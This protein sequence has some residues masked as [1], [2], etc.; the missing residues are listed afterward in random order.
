MKFNLIA[1][2]T[3]LLLNSC[4]TISI[5]PIKSSGTD[6]KVQR[7]IQSLIAEGETLAVTI[8]GGTRG[9]ESMFSISIIN[10]SDEAVYFDENT[11][12]S[13]QIGNYDKNQWERGN[14]YT[15][16]DY[17]RKAEKEATTSEILMAVAVGLSAANAGRSTSTYSGSV[18][19]STNSG[20]SY[21]G[22][23]SGQI[24]TYD[25]AKAQ[26]EIAQAQ[27][28]MYRVM[29][30]NKN[31]LENLSKTLLY[32]SEIPAKSIYS[33]FIFSPL[34]KAPDMKLLVEINNETFEFIFRRSDYQ[35]I[36]NPFIAYQ[37]TKGYIGYIYT[38]DA[39]FG[40]SAGW[41]SDG[42]SLYLDNSFNF[43]IMNGY[44]ETY[45]TYKEDGTFEY[46]YSSWEYI[47]QNAETNFVY[48][49]VIGLN[50]RVLPYLWL[51]GGVGLY[52]KNIY[53]LYAEHTLW[54]DSYDDPEWF[55]QYSPLTSPVVQAGLL[56][57]FGPT[58]LSG[59]IRYRFDNKIN[60]TGGIGLTF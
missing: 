2:A 9:K 40:I 33:G 28:N 55:G 31:Y 50:M 57:G 14:I 22:S 34:Q 18:Y 47:Y 10:K 54:D 26:Q 60:I 39:P 58:Y 4:A 15:A 19:G 24:Q 6:I 5:S 16:T 52:Y 32:S 13:F 35:E 56:L 21:Y 41:L 7:G 20:N 3:L 8:N 45:N 29:E 30:S 11:M 25:S 1:M 49:G 53:K 51:S 42:I 17:Y 27:N 59:N 36:I 48:E 23:Y 12:I 46:S 38:P 43:P 37:R 44:D